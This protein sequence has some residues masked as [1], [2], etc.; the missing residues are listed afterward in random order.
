MFC[1][2]CGKQIPDGARF[3]NF[4]GATIAPPNQPAPGPAASMSAAEI[5]PRPESGAP[6]PRPGT[7]AP[8][9][10]EGV[11]SGA[12]VAAHR[13]SARVKNIL[14]APSTEWPVVAAESTSASAIFL[15]YVAPLVAIG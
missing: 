8:Y 15:G 9:P 4:C 2:Q 11:S 3:C 12:A 10:G 14:L 5:A 13:L 7:A 1:G 6:A